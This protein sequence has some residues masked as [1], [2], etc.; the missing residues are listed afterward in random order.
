MRLGVPAEKWWS[1]S[2]L[3]AGRVNNSKTIE[4]DRRTCS[5]SE[6]NETESQ[7]SFFHVLPS[8][9]PPEG[10]FHTDGWAS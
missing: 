5:E 7:V 9:L 8:G 10:S 6:T 1:Q 3:E 4:Q 2:T